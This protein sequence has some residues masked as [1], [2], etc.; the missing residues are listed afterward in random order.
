MVS[1]DTGHVIYIDRAGH[2]VDSFATPAGLF[3]P[4]EPGA[5][6]GCDVTVDAAGN[7]Y[8]T[9]CGRGGTC[10]AVIC[11]GTLVFDR[12]HH[13]IAEFADRS[14]PLHT[15]PRFGPNGEAFALGQD[16]SL[17]RLRIT[18]PRG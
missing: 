6:N 4:A 5:A 3:P 7:T 8:V 18:L 2:K 12:S 13:P 17:V 1:D 16:R 9:G 15:S 11:A 10:T 14:V